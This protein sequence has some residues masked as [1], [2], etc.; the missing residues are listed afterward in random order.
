[1]TAFQKYTNQK[2]TNQKYTNQKYTNQKYTNQKYTNQ[3]YTN[4]FKGRLIVVKEVTQEYIA[5]MIQFHK[6]DEK[7][8]F[9]DKELDVIEKLMIERINSKD[10]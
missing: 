5:A 7:N 9:E 3:K 1:V 2:Y 6:Q 8:D 10:E 4:N